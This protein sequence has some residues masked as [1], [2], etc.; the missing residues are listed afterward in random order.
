M[1][2][3]EQSLGMGKVIIRLSLHGCILVLAPSEQQGVPME[4][5]GRKVGVAR[6]LAGTLEAL[7]G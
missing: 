2:V 7:L 5:V 4:S 6:G 1:G 3:I